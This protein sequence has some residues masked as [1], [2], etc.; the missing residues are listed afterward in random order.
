M[1]YPGNQLQKA[2]FDSEAELENWA[3]THVQQFLHSSILINGFKVATASGK[4]GVPDGFAFDFKRRRWFIIEAELLKHGVWDHIAEQVV[5]FIVACKT[6]GTLRIIRDRL[7][8]ETERTGQEN[9]I[10]QQLGCSQMQLLRSLELFIE[11]TP[12]EIAIFIDET[13]QDLQDMAEALGAPT[14]IYRINKFLVDGQ[15]RYFSPDG[16]T[17]SIE[18]EA[19]VA[20]QS[21]GT[22]L[23]A[24]QALGGGELF[25]SVRR[26][27]AY[28][29]S[30]GSIVNI[31]RS[32]YYDDTDNY[33]FGI[34][35]STLQHISDTGVSHVAFVLGETG[36]L[37]VPIDL[38]K[39]FIAVTRTSQN[40][41]GSVRHYHVYIS[42]P[43]QSELYYSQDVQKFPVQEYFIPF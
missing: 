21:T 18:T 27:K 43:P 33:W 2:L 30:D 37:K 6:P 40:E 36:V 5:R 13:N 9:L 16:T 22:E 25:A 1:A 26:F 41:D 24:V 14:S 31:K 38:V 10:T 23:D 3:K 17:P 8:D 34:N 32:K 12:P 42:P 28:K 20:S 35:E 4:Y 11:G 19:E 29:L 7:F 39:R 15:P